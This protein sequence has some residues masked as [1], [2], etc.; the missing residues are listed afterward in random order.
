MGRTGKIARL[1]KPMRDSV[2][3]LLSDGRSVADII[4]TLEAEGFGAEWLAKNGFSDDWNDQNF[5][6]WRQGGYLE[7]ERNQHR[8]DEIRMRKEMALEIAREGD[9]SKM[10]E[11][12]LHI[13]ASQIYE[14]LDTMPLDRFKELLAN[15]PQ[16]YTELLTAV[17]RISKPA[18]EFEKYRDHV[19]AQ[20]EKIEAELSKAK[21]GGGLSAETFEKINEALNLL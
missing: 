8:L 11:A 15:D 2:S 20:R 12:S 7:W 1:P 19:R 9:G 6:N 10:H 18:L 21:T 13:A 16:K 4:A 17:A 3:R 5:T 14:L